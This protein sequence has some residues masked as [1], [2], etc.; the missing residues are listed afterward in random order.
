MSVTGVNWDDPD[1]FRLVADL[2]GNGKADIVGFSNG[3]AWLS[4]NNGDGTFTEPRLAGV[5]FGLDQGWTTAEH[6]RFLTDLTGDGK[7]DIIGFGDDGVWIALNNGNGTFAAARFVLEGFCYNQ[8]WR[9]EK[10]VRLPIDLTG[11]GKADIIG[12]GDDGVWVALNNGDGTF[13]PAQ[14]VLA[15]F[16]YNQAW[17][18]ENHVRLLADLTGDHKADIVGFGDDGVYVAFNNGNGTF[19]TV[20]LAVPDF[21][22]NQ[23]WRVDSHAR[24]LADLTGDGRADIV[25]FGNAGVF[26]SVN[27]GN[28]TFGVVKFVAADMGYNQ[29]WRPDLHPRFVADVTADGRA[30]L[31][32]FGTAGIWTA[33]G[34]GDGTFAPPKFVSATFAYQQ[35]WT[36]SPDDTLPFDSWT[37]TWVLPNGAPVFQGP[38]LQSWHPRFLIDLNGDGHVDIIGFGDA[39]VW[40]ALFSAGAFAGPN[41]V[42]ADF[43]AQ[44]AVESKVISLSYL[45]SKFDTFFN[46]RYRPM[47]Q[48]SLNN[49]DQTWGEYTTTIYLDENNSGSAEYTPIQSTTTYNFSVPESVL[50]TGAAYIQDLNSSDVTLNIANGQ[51]LA[52][53]LV[54]TFE[55]TGGVE[56]KVE[57]SERGDI[58]ITQ[59]SIAAKP[60]LTIG[61]NIP[62]VWQTDGLKS[63]LTKHPDQADGADL[64]GYFDLFGWIEEIGAAMAS[65]SV[66]FAGNPPKPIFSTTFRGQTVSA[67]SIDSLRSGLFSRFVSVKAKATLQ[68][69]G[70]IDESDT[71]ASTFQSSVLSTFL[72][73]LSP[74][75]AIDPSNNPN[76]A[77]AITTRSAICRKLTSWLSG[78][79]CESQPDA[80]PILDLSSDAQNITFHYV[81]PVGALLPFPET[82]QR[83]LEQGTLKNIKN[84]IVVMMENRSFDHMLGYLSLD[85]SQG[86]K[87]RV[88]VDGYGPKSSYIPN[89]LGDQT[90]ASFPISDPAFVHHSPPHEHDLVVGQLN[91][92][93]MNGFV[94]EYAQEY[95]LRGADASAVLGYYNGSV[96][97]VYDYLAEN[98]LVCD[99]WFAAHPGPTFCN[100]FYMLTGRLNRDPSGNPELNNF[101][102]DEFVPVNTRTVFDHLTEHGVSWRYYENRYCTLRLYAKYTYDD[103]NI[104]DFNDRSKGFAAAAAAGTLPSVTFIDPNFID[105]PDPG[106]NDDAAPG[107]V[108]AGQHFIGTIVQ[109]LMRSP[110][111]SNSLLLITYDEHGGFYDHVNPMSNAYRA[112]A[113][114]VSGIDFYGVRVPAIVVSPWVAKGAAS[115]VVFDHTSIIKTISRCFMSANPPDMGERVAAAN[116]LSA[117]VQAAPVARAGLSSLQVPNAPTPSVSAQVKTPLKAGGASTDF[118]NVMRHLWNPGGSGVSS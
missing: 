82:V 1:M 25:G 36:Y 49:P 89:S 78:V 60:E 111:W 64:S 116:D 92:G 95:Q 29:G 40:T 19:G 80:R 81:P 30:D 69:F 105:E 34:A 117:V 55:T 88:D 71:V 83:P 8:G 35:G 43:G 66:T 2:T 86:G 103:V 102:G 42:L 112:K 107:N 61:K 15:N 33:V 110:Q 11:D 100:R 106:D 93:A 22:Y 108:S 18:V 12:F 94:Q 77:G 109:A 26:T 118:K 101:S 45:Q 6:P 38:W 10:H 41:F 20:S 113:K 44:S 99:K 75:D 46:N 70:G 115:S 68:L 24:L 54:I 13:A 56:I 79:D 91:G 4:L 39:G 28:G 48:V 51:P 31:V 74:N 27:N 73:A 76:P 98:F 104:V 67:T 16:G 57:G 53:D 23:G 65:V 59:L 63:F 97:T 9:V 87:G 37:Q 47:I 3:D 7:A 114:P 58:D 90:F 85:P 17:R 96:L 14:F 72:N 84:I 21:G 5:G 50:G 62:K 52:L 32:G